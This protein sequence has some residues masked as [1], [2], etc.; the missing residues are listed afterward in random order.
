M[1]GGQQPLRLVVT[2][3]MFPLLMLL[4]NSHGSTFCMPNLKLRNCLFNF[5]LILNAFL[6][7]KFFVSNRIGVA[8]T[9]AFISTSKIRALHIT[10]L[11]LTRTNRTVRPNTNIGILSKPDS[12]FL[13]TLAC[14]SVF[15]MTLFL[16]LPSSLIVFPLVSS[17][18]PLPWNASLT[19][20]L[21]II[22]SSHSA[23]RVGPIFAP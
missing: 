21:I 8:S 15:G 17:S 7:T 5:K 18:M 2:S 11:A 22:C 20:N 13:H 23:V 19:P 10:C 9:N 12:L 6:T 4:V 3:I 16:P 14:R 1:Y